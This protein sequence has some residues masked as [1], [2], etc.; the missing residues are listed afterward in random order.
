MLCN[1]IRSSLH[2]PALVRP[3]VP[4]VLSRPCF[5]MDPND[6]ARSIAR[7]AKEIRLRGKEIGFWEWCVWGAL[8]N[9]AVH[10]LFGSEVINVTQV[11]GPA[12]GP[13][14]LRGIHRVAAVRAGSSMG[15]R[16]AA[17]PGSRGH[18]PVINHFVVGVASKSVVDVESS[19]GAAAKPCPCAVRAALRAGW[20][21]KTTTLMGDCGIDVMAFHTGLVRIPSTWDNI[22]GQLADFMLAVRTKPEWQDSFM[23]C[24]DVAVAESNLGSTSCMVAI[25]FSPLPGGL[26]WLEYLHGRSLSS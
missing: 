25:R 10:M 26:G 11:F 13:E 4:T 21:L 12:G 5:L 22:R 9:V 6:I 19:A 23:A 7:R 15:F 20:V 24:Q 14:P 3:R 1:S 16:S 2:Q 18:V 17:A 8:K